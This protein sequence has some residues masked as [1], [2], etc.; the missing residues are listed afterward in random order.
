MYNIS[1]AMII[2]LFSEIP[3]KPDFDPQYRR[4]PN[5]GYDL[6][7]TETIVAVKNALRYVPENLHEILAPEFLNELM[8]R[9][10]SMVIDIVLLDLSKQNQLF[11]RILRSATEYSCR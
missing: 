11:E 9:G 10:Q 8:T 6:T 7:P 4:A 2:K 3:A 1:R 5:R